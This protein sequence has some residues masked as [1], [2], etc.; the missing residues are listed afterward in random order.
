MLLCKTIINSYAFEMR[1]ILTRHYQ[2]ISNAE[3]KILGWGHSPPC[4]GWEADIDFIGKQLRKNVVNFDSVYASELERARQ[5]AGF[6]AELYGVADVISV[7]MLKEVNYGQLQTRKKT[8][9]YENYPQHKIDS[10]FVY[11]NGESFMQ[12]QQRSTQ[13][14]SSLALMHPEQTILIVAHAG[15]IRGLIS[16]YLGLEYNSSL[17]YSIPFRYIGDFQFDHGNCVRYDELGNSSG[18]VKEGAIQLPFEAGQL[19]S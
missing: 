17:K 5:T 6:Y 7:P 11:P 18:F 19:L 16:H 15:L 8:W 12:M 3:G 2:T 9:V 14:L 1:V 4:P 13:F 10:G